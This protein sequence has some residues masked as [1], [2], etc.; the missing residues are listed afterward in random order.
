MTISE[1]MVG[2]EVLIVSMFTIHYKSEGT[3]AKCYAF[4]CTSFEMCSKPITL[5]LNLILLKGYYCL[6]SQSHRNSIP[7]T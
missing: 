6:L 2:V 1:S 4:D 7:I 5:S 3:G